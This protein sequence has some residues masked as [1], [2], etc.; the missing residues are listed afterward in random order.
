MKIIVTGGAGFIG[1]ALCRYLINFT[2]AYVINVDK[3]TYAANVKSLESVKDNVRYCFEHLDIC[4]KAAVVAIFKK[5]EPDYLVHLAAETH[6]D[7]SIDNPKIFLETNIL[8]TYNLLEVTKNYLANTKGNVSKESFRFLHVSTDEVYGSLGDTGFFTEESVYCPSSPYS[9][10]KASADHLVNAYFRTYNL[11]VLIS[12]CSNNYGPF[13]FPE[14]LIPLTIIKAYNKEA[15]PIYGDGKNIRHWLFVE[16]HVEALYLILTKGKLGQKYNI[17]GNSEESNITIVKKICNIL[18]KNSKFV[19]SNF[20]SHYDF[21]NFV[22]DRPGHDFRYAIDD[23]KIR[24][25]LGW[26]PKTN[27]NDGLERTVKWY[28]N[29]CHWWEIA[30]KELSK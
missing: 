16:D 29:N 26:V 11:P 2:D 9:A 13:Q 5:Y 24:N 15:L 20:Q 12:N 23:I 7:R 1:S 10:S 3:L 22:Q 14:K 8:G 27:I 17:G 4:D 19:D 25:E 18:D 6:V 28:I 21:V 30:Y